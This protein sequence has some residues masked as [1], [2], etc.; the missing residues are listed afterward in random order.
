MI[1]GRTGPRP[2]AALVSPPGGACH[3][4]L[5]VTSFD[6]AGVT[7]LGLQ[8]R[9][10]PTLGYVFDPHRLALPCWAH[11]LEGRPAALLVTIDRHV[12]L[13][14]PADPDRVP[15]RDAGVQ[16]LEEHARRSLDP[17]N[18]DH[19]LAAVESGLVDDVLC[20][21]R[22]P[23]P[24]CVST[25]TWRDH[26]GGAHEVCVAPTI[27]RVVDAW[28]EA[29][30]PAEAWDPRALLGGARPV[31]LD[32]DLDAFTT[33]SDADPTTVIPWP[34]DAI[35]EFLLPPGSGPVWDALLSRCVALT[36]AR[37][38]LHCGGVVASGRLFEEV[39]EVLFRELLAVD[40]P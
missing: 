10:G 5:V 37:E 24:G 32:V 35:R 40:L 1:G 25:G 11:A 31:L 6:V 29:T 28:E 20:V 26:R 18:V 16:S 34:R 33:L 4:G 38:P 8:P 23:L 13:V 3:S 9:R 22:S 7:V 30:P 17:R 14:A 27:Q 36:V 21:A 19:V 2:S 39:A 12:D 15:R